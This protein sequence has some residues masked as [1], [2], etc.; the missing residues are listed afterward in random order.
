LCGFRRRATHGLR[1]GPTRILWID[2]FGAIRQSS[3]ASH[4][5]RTNGGGEQT[6]YQSGFKQPSM[7]S[8]ESKLGHVDI[9]SITN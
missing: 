3:L 9:K 7:P 1:F 8:T 2:S 4:A 5:V 6:G